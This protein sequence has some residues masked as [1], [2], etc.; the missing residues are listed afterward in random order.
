MLSLS[1]FLSVLWQLE[2]S[3][4]LHPPSNGD[5]VG[6]L[7][8]KRVFVDEVN[9]LIGRR[10]YEYEDRK[11]LWKSKRIVGSW[12]GQRFPG[13]TEVDVY[14][15]ALEYTAGPTGARNPTAEEREYANRAVVLYQAIKR[16]G[17]WKR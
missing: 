14:K 3:C 12:I 13:A 8:I 11:S 17:E 16:G 7:Q 9:R 1:I 6:P 5:C 10:V 4:R 2:S 15:I